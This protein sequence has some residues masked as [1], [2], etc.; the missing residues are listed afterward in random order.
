MLKL[1]HL[2]LRRYPK[3]GTI[4]RIIRDVKVRYI[5]KIEANI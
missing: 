2:K 3:T 1:R 4:L 5:I